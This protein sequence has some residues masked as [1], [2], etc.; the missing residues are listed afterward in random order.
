[1]LICLHL[2]SWKKTHATQCEGNTHRWKN[3]QNLNCFLIHAANW[4]PT[5]QFIDTAVIRFLPAVE[6]FRLYGHLDFPEALDFFFPFSGRSGYF[7][8]VPVIAKMELHQAVCLLIK[9]SPIKFDLM[10]GRVNSFFTQKRYVHCSVKKTQFVAV[11][12]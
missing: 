9:K 2:N 11:S 5:Y 12:D 10:S 1:M 8:V 7:L 4:V 3:L 6:V